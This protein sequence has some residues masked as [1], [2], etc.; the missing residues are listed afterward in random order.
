MKGPITSQTH[1]LNAFQDL[2]PWGGVVPRA[3]GKPFIVPPT[4]VV[5]V[6]NSAICIL[7][8]ER[9]PTCALAAQDCGVFRC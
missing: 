7:S 3:L 1:S 4:I 9:Q 6:A 8:V 5:K 2:H